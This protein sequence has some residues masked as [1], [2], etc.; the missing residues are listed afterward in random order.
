MAVLHEHFALLNVQPASDR[1]MQLQCLINF[2]KKNLS[3][4]GLCLSVPLLFAFK[5]VINRFRRNLVLKGNIICRMN[6]IYVSMFRL[7][8]I[9]A[10]TWLSTNYVALKPEHSSPHLQQP[11]TGPYPEPGESTPHPPSLC[12]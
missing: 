10:F 4:A 2:F 11:A 1:R 6:L 9:R 5:K 3:L 7:N 12:P 8:I